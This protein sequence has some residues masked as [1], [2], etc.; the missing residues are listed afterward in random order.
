MTTGILI[1]K[2]RPLCS[3]EAV[4]WND[5]IEAKTSLDDRNVLSES[6]KIMINR[7]N[8]YKT[9]KTCVYGEHK[10]KHYRIDHKLTKTNGSMLSPSDL[11]I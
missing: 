4:Y 1:S 2:A 11:E 5:D 3:L 7:P 8:E 9:I 6:T 10:R